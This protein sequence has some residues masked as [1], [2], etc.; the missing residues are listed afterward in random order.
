M[1]QELVMVT[2][3]V[4]V[5]VGQELVMWLLVEVQWERLV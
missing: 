5:L 4:L 2:Q 3:K 1:G